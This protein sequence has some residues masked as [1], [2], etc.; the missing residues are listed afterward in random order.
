[1]LYFL[2]PLY[3]EESNLELLHENLTSILAEDE[4]FYVFS[5]DGSVDSSVDVIHKLFL[6]TNFVVLGDDK[7][8]G[9]GHAFNIGFEWILNHSKDDS[10]KVITLEAD[11]TSDILILPKMLVIS[12]MGY[13]LVLASIYAQGGGFDKTS[14]FR[15]V[16]SAV[17]NLFL[18]FYFN[19][20]VLTLSSF[21]RIYSISILRKIKEKNNIL[22]KETGFISMIEILIKAIRVNATI[23]EIPMVLYSGKRKGKSKMKILKTTIRYLRF[24][25]AN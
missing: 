19:I 20:K 23:I 12:R 11:N 3:N 13:D 10:D 14:F 4:K 15:K 18:R 24:L 6:N 1:M 22:I 8:H 21:Y 9:P 2:I 25:F 16:I 5:D 7:N 17:A